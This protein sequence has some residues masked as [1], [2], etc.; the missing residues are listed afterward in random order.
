[1]ANLRGSTSEQAQ[2]NKVTAAALRLERVVDELD[3]SLRGFVL[4]RN[5]GI[6]QSWDRARRDLPSAIAG[7]ERL[8]EG[9]PAQA[10]LARHD[11]LRRPGRT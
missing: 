6:R 10:R 5:S 11:R 7:L 8:V 1:M 4:T 2:A 9:Q 3:Q